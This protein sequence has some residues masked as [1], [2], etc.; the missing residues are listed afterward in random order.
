M[1][2]GESFEF[3]FEEQLEADAPGDLVAITATADAVRGH[4]HKSD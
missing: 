2:A 1:A 4:H 3:D